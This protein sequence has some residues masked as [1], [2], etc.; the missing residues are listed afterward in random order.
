M[1]PEQASGEAVD[2]RSDQF[3]LGS[4]LYEMATGPAA[5]PAEDRRRDAGGDHARG[6]ASR[7][8][9]RHRKLPAAPAL[10]RRA[11]PRQG[12]RG[13]LRLDARPGARPD[14]A[15]RSPLGRTSASRDVA[16]APAGTSASAALSA[17]GPRPLPCSALGAALLAPAA[18]QPSLPFQR[19]TFRAETSPM[20]A[21]HPTARPS[22]TARAGRAG[23]SR[24]F[25]TA[26]KPRVA[27][28]RSFPAPAPRHLQRT[29][30]MALSVKDY[31]LGLGARTLARAPWRGGGAARGA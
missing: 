8:R 6:A 13:A 12:P 28:A 15:P 29:G 10:D 4:M 11:L 27:V 20:P 30:E 18:A 26:R 25:S 2:F 1:S 31:P 17:A 9:E 21:S 14:S 16:A 19:L 22:S 24:L 5:V 7:S 3:S 23:R